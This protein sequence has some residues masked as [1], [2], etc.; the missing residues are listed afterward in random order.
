MLVRY[1][2]GGQRM[3]STSYDELWQ[4]AWGDIQRHGPV[5]RHAT[6]DLLR[7]VASLNVRTILDAGCGS[8][9][10][11]EALARENRYE[12]SGIDVSEQALAIA[13]KRVPDASLGILDLQRDW[14]PQTYDLVI[15]LQVVEHLLDDVS[16]IRNMARMASRYLLIATMQGRMRKSELAIG[17]IR[18]YSEVE[19]RKKIEAAGA[20]IV[21][22]RGWGFP[23]YS[24]LYRTAA[25]WLPG[26]PPTGAMGKGSQMV[27]AALYQLYRLNLPG[28]GD[29]ITALAK[30]P[31][32]GLKQQ[33]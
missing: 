24:P 33:S 18:N 31:A 20:E 21:W 26:G 14:R 3:S 19:L 12:L 25:E 9:D 27:A 29:V 2:A 23:F 7:T 13:R 32:G 11:L 1:H 16:A 6:E 17:H 10:N 8:G 28:R 15:S 22:I 30:V 5:H 4:T